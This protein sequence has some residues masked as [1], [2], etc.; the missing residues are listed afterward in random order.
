MTQGFGLFSTRGTTLAYRQT[1]PVPSAANPGALIT[2]WTI[3]T[4]GSFIVIYYAYIFVY[5]LNSD[6]DLGTFWTNKNIR[7]V[8][9]GRPVS[10]PFTWASPVGGDRGTREENVICWGH[11]FDFNWNSSSCVLEFMS[12]IFEMFLLEGISSDFSGS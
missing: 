11:F 3:S 6:I 8:L 12:I 9:P 10:V 1:E 4:I 7:N 5:I 2:D